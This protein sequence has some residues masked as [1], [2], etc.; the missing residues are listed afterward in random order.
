[1][2]QFQIPSNQLD[3]VEN[4]KLRLYDRAEYTGTWKSYEHMHSFT[5]IFFI[6][7]GEG[8]F[9]TLEGD[10]P[11]HK[12]MVVINTPSVPHTEF[13]SEKNPLAYAAFAVDDLTF[14]LPN[15]E[16]Q[17]TFF[18][19]FSDHYDTL[20]EVLIVIEREYALKP[21]FWQRAIVNE[22]NNFMLFLLRNTQWLEQKQFKMHLWGIYGHLLQKTHSLHWKRPF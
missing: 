22:F 16:Q 5:E 12:G 20:Y 2:K 7:S 18:F 11:I 17:K 14:T 4:F 8:V 10:T 9:H 13:S 19:D 15:A 3:N 21:P 1:M 6:T